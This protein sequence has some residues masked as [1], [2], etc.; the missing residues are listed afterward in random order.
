MMDTGSEGQRFVEYTSSPCML[1]E[2]DAGVPP[3]FAAPSVP[4]GAQDWADVRLWRKAKRAVLIER[5]LAIS[6]DD[7]A[8][9][10]IVVTAHLTEMLEH[11]RGRLIGFYWPFKGEYDTRPLTHDLH[12]RGCR[13]ALPIVIER[14]KPLMF[15][16]WWPGI[17]MSHDIW[18]IPVPAEGEAVLPDVL[19][20][21]LVGFDG[22]GYRLGYGGGYYDRTLATCRTK[23]RTIGI[24]YETSRISTI[25]AQP[26]DI[27]MDEIVTSR[28]IGLPR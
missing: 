4:A 28:G 13:F 8:A 9:H 26:H 2:I 22:Q 7:R 18:N 16:E 15:R 14:A 20:V 6:V 5:R 23:P 24:G 3:E 10:A 12:R 19:L 21:P 17:R 1:H 25:H 11:E 27:P